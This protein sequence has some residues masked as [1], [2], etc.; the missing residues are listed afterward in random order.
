M[1]VLHVILLQKAVVGFFEAIREKGDFCGPSLMVRIWVFGG[2]ERDL[3]GG[4]GAM[5]STSGTSSPPAV[6]TSV[7]GC[8]E[9]M[10]WVR[11]GFETPSLFWPAFPGC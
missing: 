8:C 4:T 2:G 6:Q 1:A 7:S 11:R 9:R 3:P 10:S 5:Y